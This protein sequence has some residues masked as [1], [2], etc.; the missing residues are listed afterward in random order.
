MGF[1]FFIREVYKG[2]EVELNLLHK[3]ETEPSLSEAI[4]RSV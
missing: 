1:I 3:S 2:K 4:Q